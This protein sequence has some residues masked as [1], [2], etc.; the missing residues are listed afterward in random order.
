MSVDCYFINET[1]KQVLES[2]MLYADFEDN[3]QL[4]CYL[5]FCQGDTIRL[6]NENSAFVDEFCNLGMHKEYKYIR[7]RDY[8]IYPN[9]DLYENEDVER[10][11]KDISV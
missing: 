10:L 1:K 6:V 2:K 11:R 9:S 3:Q 5:S 7:L 4:L 8:K